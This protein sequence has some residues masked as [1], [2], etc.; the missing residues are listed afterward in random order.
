MTSSE[1][2]YFFEFSDSSE[3]CITEARNAIVVHFSDNDDFD[4][5]GTTSAP[6]PRPPKSNPPLIAQCKLKNDN[7]AERT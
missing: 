1:N 2:Q 5:P 3:G 4:E 6:V 7:G